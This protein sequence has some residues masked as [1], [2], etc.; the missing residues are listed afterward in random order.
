MLTV[1]RLD[2]T[3]WKSIIKQ[4][5]GNL[6]PLAFQTKSEI[7]YIFIFFKLAALPALI[8]FK[9]Y[10]F[11]KESTV[12]MKSLRWIWDIWWVKWK[13]KSEKSDSKIFCSHH[14]RAEYFIMPQFQSKCNLVKLATVWKVCFT[15]IHRSKG[16]YSW[17]NIQ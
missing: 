11:T 13:S 8:F 4:N 6:H 2:L 5:C 1:T 10:L 14:L 12:S 15:R 3:F 17:R 9:S 7:L 16:A